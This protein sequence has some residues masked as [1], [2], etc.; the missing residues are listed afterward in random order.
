MIIRFIAL[1]QVRDGRRYDNRWQLT[2]RHNLPPTP[3]F[4]DSPATDAA[5]EI[6]RRVIAEFPGWR[7]YQLGT[8]VL[9]G[10]HLAITAK[11]LLEDP[12]RRFGCKQTAEGLEVTGY[13]IRLLQIL[14]RPIYR[15][16]NVSR[17]WIAPTDIAVL[18]IGLDRTSEDKPEVA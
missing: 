4:R 7:F 3:A 1:R 5:Q 11:D 17:A 12:M 18:H 16:W 15:T 2:K 14:P 6:A 13:S 9:I 8:A 10:G